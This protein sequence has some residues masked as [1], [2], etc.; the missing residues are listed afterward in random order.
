M[1]SLKLLVEMT[2]V[3]RKKVGW[4][5]VQLGRF[6]RRKDAVEAGKQLQERGIIQ[7]FIPTDYKA[8]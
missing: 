1:L 5:Q 8:P 2:D 3:A 4:C 6:A 7:S